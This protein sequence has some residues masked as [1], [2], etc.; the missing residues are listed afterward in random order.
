MMLRAY[1]VDDESLAIDRLTR[2][3][4][5][6]G[7]VEVVGASTNPRTAIEFLGSNSADVLFLDIQMPGMTGFELLAKLP[8]PP[9]V[10]IT[11][12]YDQYALKAFE[13]NSI[14]YLLKPVDPVQLDRAL[15]KAERLRGSV[16]DIR[17]L[18]EEV[19]VSVRRGPAEYPDRIASRTGERVSFIELSRV[20][21]F[22]AEDKLTF[23]VADGKAHCVDHTISDLEERLDPKRFIRI[24]RATLMNADWVREIAPTFAGALVVRL[25]DARGTELTVA[26]SRARDVKAKLGF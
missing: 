22:Q 14:D 3:L 2:L 8:S 17:K 4:V 21:H 5:N 9:I 7:R 16:P 25:K 20:T 11:T 23:A 12:A 1:L 18:L 19:A 13:V 10:I 26:R 15:S 24:H 6:T